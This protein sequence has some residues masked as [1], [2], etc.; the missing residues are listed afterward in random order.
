MNI[1]LALS[2]HGQ[3]AHLREINEMQYSLNIVPFWSTQRIVSDHKSAYISHGQNHMQNYFNI[4]THLYCNAVFMVEKKQ[5]TP[6]AFTASSLC[7]NTNSYK[8]HLLSSQFALIIV[9]Y[10][11]CRGN[12]FHINELC[13]Y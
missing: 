7:C 9:F 8:T 1:L 11:F 12:F 4:L 3:R 10:T 5:K 2:F 6:A 13:Y